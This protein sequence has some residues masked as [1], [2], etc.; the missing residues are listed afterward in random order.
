MIDDTV[1]PKKK[2]KFGNNKGKQAKNSNK[3][4]PK[5]VGMA[6]QYKENVRS[7]KYASNFAHNF[8]GILS[9][10]QTQEIKAALHKGHQ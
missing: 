2:D 6:V 5:E 8:N 4:E 1:N 7:I 9:T 10:C 3:L